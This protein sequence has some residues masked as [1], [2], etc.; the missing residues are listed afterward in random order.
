[1]IRWIIIIVAIGI[2][3]YFTLYNH[4]RNIGKLRSRKRQS[5]GKNYFDKKKKKN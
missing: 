3:F 4:K 5:F 1:M 2:L